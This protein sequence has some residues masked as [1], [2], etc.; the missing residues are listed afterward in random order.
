MGKEKAK[1][2]NAEKGAGKNANAAGN[3]SAHHESP[4][5]KESVKKFEH[6]LQREMER[7]GPE[8]TLAELSE[9]ANA[10]TLVKLQ[11]LI[12][13]LVKGNIVK[14]NE[15]E[16][17]VNGQLQKIVDLRN[18]MSIKVENKNVNYIQ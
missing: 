17:E 1:E 14:K 13:L 2:K 18:K 15:L 8:E 3:R 10:M 11:A 12:D 4:H 9:F 7:K 5:D 16:A 6:F